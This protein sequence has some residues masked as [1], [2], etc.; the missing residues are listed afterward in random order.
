MESLGFD[1]RQRAVLQTLTEDVVKTSEI[2]G[3]ILD[4]EQVRSSISRRLGIEEG[5]LPPTDRRVEGV[6]E[7]MLDA[8]GRYDEPLTGQRIFGWHAALFPT[9]R[10]GIR[11]IRTG[12]WRDDQTGPMQ[13]V[14][15]PIG[16]ERVHYEAP[17]APR[18][19][20]EMSRFLSWINAPSEEDAVLTASLAHLWFVTIHPLDDGNGRVAR[21]LAD[22]LLARSEQSRDRFYSMSA[23]I[24][25]ERSAYYEVLERTQKGTLNVTEWMGWFLGC[26]DRALE[27]AEDTLSSVLRKARFWES[28]ST[29]SL[30]ERQRAMLNRLLDGFEGKLTTSKWAK[31]AKCSQ[32]SAL[33]DIADLVEQRLLVRGEAGGR[34]TS[35]RLLSEATARSQEPGG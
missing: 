18:L 27:G 5:G 22:L 19:G 15:G 29:A 14:S 13:V 9:G 12:A 31:I 33:R 34:S 3:E 1:F 4:A 30:N 24:R 7:L 21:A 6:V 26:M 25:R 28:A 8:T 2:E 20:A 16:G 10:S 32:D 35:Y 11:R 23:Q 17:E